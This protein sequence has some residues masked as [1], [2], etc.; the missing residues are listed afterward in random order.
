[1]V[2]DTVAEIRAGAE[3]WWSE[4]MERAV[5]AAAGS[6][7]VKGQ[8]A[9]YTSSQTAEQIG[10]NSSGPASVPADP[11]AVVVSAEPG[12]GPGAELSAAQA[13]ASGSEAA[14]PEAQQ[15]DD[16]SWSMG[17]LT[18]R[19]MSGSPTQKPYERARQTKKDEP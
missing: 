14:G 5:R 18:F 12:V 9:R 13:E 2:V 3:G 19:S 1:V 11:A 15:E 6:A 17:G 8:S 10:A 7:C 16:G 4:D